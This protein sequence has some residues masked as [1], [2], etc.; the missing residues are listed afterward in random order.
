MIVFPRRIS[1]AFHDVVTGYYAAHGAAPH[2]QKEAIQMQ[3]IIGLVGM[4]LALVPR[5][6]TNLQISGMLYLPLVDATQEIETGLVWRIS[7]R[8]ANLK[9]FLVEAV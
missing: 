9:I 3:T 1:P 6:T 2:I 5:S 8:T 7:D 4:G